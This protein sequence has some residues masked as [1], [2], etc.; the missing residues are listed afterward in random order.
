MTNAKTLIKTLDAAT[1]V[2]LPEIGSWK[3][4]A[5]RF[6]EQQ[7]HAVSAAL[8]AGRPLLVRGEPGLGKSQLARALATIWRWRLITATIHSRTEV[9]DLLYSIDYVGR[10]A[11]ANRRQSG[12]LELD[13]LSG[14]VN[15]GP[16]WKALDP[17]KVDNQ[18]ED[19]PSDDFNSGVERTDSTGC[20]LLIDEI[21]KAHPDV[22]NALLEVLGNGEF[23]VP[24]TGE[25]AKQIPGHHLFIVVT[26]N[27]DRPLSDAFLRRCAVVKLDLGDSEIDSLVGIARA[28]RQHGRLSARIDDDVAR[29]TAEHVVR[30][31]SGLPAGHYKPGA[32]E[33][34]DLLRVIDGMEE[35]QHQELE[36]MLG[37]LSAFLLNKTS[38]GAPIG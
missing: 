30:Y 8:L 33:Y 25:V 31:R 38:I 37:T 6:S 36:T 35:S 17:K 9:D 11:D 22:P 14:Y 28:H 12:E 18:N 26:A 10:L 7:Q 3:R 13:S 32:S 4:S 29:T 23:S 34:L 27:E 20:V 2:E 16:V 21:D 5:H 24:Q 15:P 19:W 1:S